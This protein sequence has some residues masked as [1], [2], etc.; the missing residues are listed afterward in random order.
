MA[1]WEEEKQ[2]KTARG[3][4]TRGEQVDRKF[5]PCHV[6]SRHLL[7]GLLYCGHNEGE[8]HPMLADFIPAKKGQRGHWDFYICARKKNSRDLKCDS[9]RI[10]ARV[11]ETSIIQALIEQVLTRDNLR[12][13]ADTIAQQLLE[14]NQSASTRLSVV[15]TELQQVERQID[16]LLSAIEDM[17]LSPS[18]KE[19]LTKRE[20]ECERLKSHAAQLQALVVQVSDIPRG[21]MTYSMN[22]LTRCASRCK[23]R[24]QKSLDVRF[25][26]L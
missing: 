22:G 1:W 13:I 25:D 23:V 16:N 9:K 6:G 18:L 5:E 8:K 3:K 11:L 4:K 7:S 12:P 15:Q 10:G 21:A 24:I 17:G 14:T 19:K 26:I 20:A 2:R